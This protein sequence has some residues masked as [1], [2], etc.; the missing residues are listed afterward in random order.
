MLQVTFGIRTDSIE[1]PL[2]G[3]A[4]HISREFMYNI[5][6]LNI[7]YSSNV[8]RNLTGAMSNTIDFFPLLQYLPNKITARGQQLN[9]DIVDT[10]GG[11]IKHVEQEMNQGKDLPPSLTTKRLQIKTQEKLSHKEMTML[12]AAFMIGGVETVSKLSA[13]S[14]TF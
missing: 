7:V 10:W 2:V 6:N 13:F 4:L 8:C 9:R 1:D 14:D 5:Q 3:K 11:L 12:T